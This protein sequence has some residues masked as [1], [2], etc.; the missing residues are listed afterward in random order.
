MKK[1]Y[2]KLY[3][4]P[5]INCPF[6]QLVYPKKSAKEKKPKKQPIDPHQI[7]GALFDKILIFKIN[8]I[9][10]GTSK[11]IVVGAREV[12]VKEIIKPKSF[13]DEFGDYDEYGDEK[14]NEEERETSEE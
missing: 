3:A 8:K 4:E 13:F 1:L 2:A 6:S 12:L 5:K 10:L 7:V 14:D 9:F 11:S